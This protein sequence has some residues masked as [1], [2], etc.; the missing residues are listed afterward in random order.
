MQATKRIPYPNPLPRRTPK[1][2]HWEREHK[3]RIKQHVDR[4]PF[5]LRFLH[6]STRATEEKDAYSCYSKLYATTRN[7]CVQTNAPL[8][9]TQPCLCRSSHSKI[10]TAPPPL[11]TLTPLKSL[12][13][14]IFFKRNR[15]RNYVCVDKIPA[16]PP[17]PPLTSVLQP[18]IPTI[19]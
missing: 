15:C 13:P 19:F 17:L 6:P 12:L 4:C 5:P 8:H 7:V 2:I 14:S 3:Q 18:T 10:S 11:T 16:R 9:N 1:T